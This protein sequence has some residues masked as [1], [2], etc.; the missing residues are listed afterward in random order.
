MCG[1]LK[2]KVM[3]GGT[4]ANPAKLVIAEVRGYLVGLGVGFFVGVGVGDGDGVGLVRT[5][6]ACGLLVMGTFGT[7]TGPGP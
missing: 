7:E 1:D 6:L 3:A 4:L 2:D 5:P